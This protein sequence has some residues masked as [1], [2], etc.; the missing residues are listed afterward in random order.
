M[1][2]IKRPKQPSISSCLRPYATLNSLETLRNN[3]MYEFE[4]M[5][6]SA[7]EIYSDDPDEQELLEETF[8]QRFFFAELF[9]HGWVTITDVGGPICG[10]TIPGAGLDIYGRFATNR[11]VTINQRL[12]LDLNTDDSVIIYCSLLRQGFDGNGNQPVPIFQLLAP[13]CN[14]MA[15]IKR[16]IVQNAK[17]M[18]VPIIVKGTRDQMFSLKNMYEKYSDGDDVIPV[19]TDIMDMKD[20]MEALDLHVPMYLDGLANQW[21]RARN[22]GLTIIGMNNTGIEKQERLL[23]GEVN[24]NNENINVNSQSTLN[25][26]NA[27][28]KDFNRIFGY[29]Y[30]CRLKDVSQRYGTTENGSIQYPKYTNESEVEDDGNVAD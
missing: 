24:A 30:Q 13:I 9:S 17:A 2:N 16:A 1:A 29:N 25:A 3:Y 20:S 21:E 12:T 11:L 27:G 14:E 10:Q 19:D 15:Y 5:F 4:Q 26:I 6:C 22:N 23:V 8:D 18:G 7:Y 28:L